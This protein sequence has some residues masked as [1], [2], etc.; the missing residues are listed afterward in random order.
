[1]DNLFLALIDDNNKIFN[2]LMFETEDLD[3]AQQCIQD[4]QAKDGKF[5]NDGSAEV[6]G[7]YLNNMFYPEKPYDSWVANPNEP[8]WT[9]PVPKPDSGFWKWNEETVSW[10]E[11]PLPAIP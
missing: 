8:I 6:N 10:Q 3:L 7:Y 5:C 1:M 2:L 4:S 11:L 9:A